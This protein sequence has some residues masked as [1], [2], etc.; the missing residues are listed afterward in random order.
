MIITNQQR[1]R[2]NRN[3]RVRRTQ[4]RVRNGSN[5]LRFQAFAVE[6]ERLEPGPRGGVVDYEEGFAAG[7]VGDSQGV[8]IG[9]AGGEVREGEFL[10]LDVVV[11]GVAGEV[12]AG[13]GGGGGIGE[14]ALRLNMSVWALCVSSGREAY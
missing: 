6:T 7:V 4:Q 13:F 12:E 2:I 8:E 3:D 14:D 5:M 9:R 11:G 10:G 1:R